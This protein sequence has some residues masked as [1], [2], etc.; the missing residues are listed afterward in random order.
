MY[1]NSLIVKTIFE[2]F[3]V[4]CFYIFVTKYAE[5]D[6]INIQKSLSPLDNEKFRVLQIFSIKADLLCIFCKCF[7]VILFIITFCTCL[8]DA[9]IQNVAFRAVRLYDDALL[10]DATMHDAVLHC[11][12]LRW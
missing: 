6:F 3:D 10:N 2:D 11:I 7:Y 8:K 9:R 5:F 1:R 4:F 12:M